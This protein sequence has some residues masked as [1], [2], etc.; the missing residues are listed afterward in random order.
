[1]MRLA[2]PA[3]QRKALF[4]GM[5][6]LVMP[7]EQLQTI[8]DLM[9]AFGPP[10]AQIEALQAELG[11]Q[12]E[13]V[14]AMN[15]RLAHMERA[16][17]RLAVACEQLVMFQEPFVRMTEAMTGQKVTRVQRSGGTDDHTNDEES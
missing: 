14:E 4:E 10:L 12:R 6:N 17:E 3:D 8:V 1:M 13:Q 15:D 7:G 2:M 5:S 11:E 16:A 9:D